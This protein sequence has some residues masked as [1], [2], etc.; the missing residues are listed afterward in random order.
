[1]PRVSIV[2]PFRN[3]ESTL[4]DCL[5]SIERQTM[6]DWEL[7]AVDDGSTDDSNAVVTAAASRD[8]RIRLLSPGRVGLVAALNLGLHMSRA[9]IVARMDA[10][11]VM[12]PERLGLQASHLADHATIDLVS[13]QVRLF[14]EDAIR[15]GYDEYVRW[16]NACLTAEDVSEEIYVESPFAHPSVM[17]RRQTVLDAG[18]YRDGGFPEDYELWLRLNALGHRMDKLPHTLLDWRESPDRLSR[19]DDRYSREAFDRLR[20]DYLSRDPRL[21]ADR[22]VVFWGAGRKTRQRARH[23]VA[24]GVTPS[25]YV[26]I[27]P[28]KIGNRPGGV[29][30]H[31]PEWLDRRD[32]P[33]VLAWVTNHGA[34]DLIA[35]R[36]REMGYVRGRDWLGVG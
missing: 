27:D 4:R 22:E 9:E 33:F 5:G 31:P 14:P 32:R 29:E 16:Q 35:A 20:A 6:I 13:C 8:S 34:R 7:V 3:A 21:T 30:V 2:M 15:A 12:A 18:G 10:D 23:V 24:L 17:F 25:G 36:L 19:T 1:M 11:D 26:D 28:R